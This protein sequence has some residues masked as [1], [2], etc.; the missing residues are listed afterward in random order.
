MPRISV[1]LVLRNPI[2]F[3]RVDNRPSPPS[4][5]FSPFSRTG[6]TTIVGCSVHE[7]GRRYGGKLARA[8]NGN[9]YFGNR[10]ACIR[11]NAVPQLYP[12]LPLSPP[13][14]TCIS[15]EGG[16]VLDVQ[17]T[18]RI[19]P[20]KTVVLKPEFNVTILVPTPSS[21]FI[22]RLHRRTKERR[23]ASL[24]VNRRLRE[25]AC[26]ASTDRSCRY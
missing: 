6:V 5:F 14:F 17:I 12:F 23:L 9:V 4:S 22:D 24:G 7:I 10:I 15:N 8:T 13:Y 11:E 1:D 21:R 2:P 25:T 18:L 20:L 19:R 3:Q 16:A 26:G